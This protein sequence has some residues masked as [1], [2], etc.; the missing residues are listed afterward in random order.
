MT[1]TTRWLVGVT[2][3]S[4]LTLGAPGAPVLAQDASGVQA[5]A[6]PSQDDPADDHRLGPEDVLS[7]SV[8]QA[9]EMNSTV[10]VA[11][12][13]HV[14]LPLVGAVEAGGLTAY[15]L[16]EKLEAILRERYIKHPDVT[17]RVTEVRS[18]PVTVGGAVR[19]PGVFQVGQ[20]AT[21]LNV[22]S[23]AGG[24]SDD[25]GDVVLIHRGAAGA[26][27]DAPVEEVPLKTLLDEPTGST[28]VPVGPGDIVTVTRAA[29]VYVLGA[30]KKPGAF[31][32]R[33]HDRLTVL[34]ALALVEGPTAT[35]STGE[36]VLIRTSDEGDRT[37]TT[38]DLNAVVKGKVPDLAMQPR[39][40][41][42]VPQSGS[43]AVA[44][45]TL[46]ALTRIVTLR[47][48]VIP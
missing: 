18:R 9:P 13:G 45:A 39:D 34:R 44:R 10:R 3:W 41:L 16:E 30:V 35:A 38:F 40:I 2:A 24:V 25:A 23:L 37:E 43:K 27:E 20:S 17:V 26:G 33:S 31:S 12:S 46:D 8:L 14:S 47:T 6:V 29:T 42:F 32:L 4:V 19:R 7:V 15:E 36:L 1:M 28:N 11:V 48:A 21:L 22:L 5:T